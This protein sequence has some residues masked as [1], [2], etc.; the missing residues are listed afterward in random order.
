MKRGAKRG[1][2]IDLRS[3]RGYYLDYA[4]WADPRGP[5]DDEGLPLTRSV[6]GVPLESPGHVARYALGNLELY[7]ESGTSERRDRFD[8]ACR[9]LVRNLETIPG[10]F[11]GWAIPDPPEAF[12]GELGHGWLGGAVQAECVCALARAVALVR[13]E[14]AE[15]AIRSAIPGFGVPVGDAGFLREVGE[16]GD[17]GGLASLAFVEEY[18]MTYRISMTLGGHI[19][20]LWAI[21]DATRTTSEVIVPG[22]F[23]RCLRGLLFVLDRYDTGFWTRA[24]LDC[25]WRGV[26]LAGPTTHSEHVLGLEI[27]HEMTQALPLR[28][29]ADRWLAYETSPLS[30]FAAAARAAAFDLVNPDVAT[31]SDPSRL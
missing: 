29:T 9:W 2:H 27:L 21:Y 12:K 14:G 15:E 4:S 19:R 20:A 8:S 25:G 6:D 13:L 18:P 3:P 23:D 24:D 30:R 5:L 7:L 28:E 1:R 16:P 31:A 10:S 17:E 11:A 22:L 26:R